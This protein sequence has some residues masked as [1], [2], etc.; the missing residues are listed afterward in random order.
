M[1]NSVEVFLWGKRIGILYQNENSLYADFEYDRDFQ[2]SGIELSPF[3]M[4]LGGRTNSVT[5]L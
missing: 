4:P 2:K 3:K 1:I 5:L